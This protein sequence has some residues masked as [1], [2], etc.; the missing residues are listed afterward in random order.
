MPQ[1]IALGGVGGGMGEDVAG[2][3][4]GGKGEFGEQGANGLGE[5]EQ[6]LDAAVAVEPMVAAEEFVG[7]FAGHD[8]FEAGVAAG[9]IQEIDRNAGGGAL[10]FFEVAD[11]MR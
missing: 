9:A 3:G 5:V 10:R 6:G 2:G 8:D 11:D 1:R 7:S 4:G